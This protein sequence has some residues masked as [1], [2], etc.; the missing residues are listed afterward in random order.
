MSALKAHN[1]G[2]MVGRIILLGLA[3]ASWS[4]CDCEPKR[5]PQDTTVPDGFE[6]VMKE[7]A[8]LSIVARN[9]LIRGD[10]PVA[11]QSMRKLAFFMEHVRFPHWTVALRSSSSRHRR[12][13]T[14]KC[15]CGG[16][17]GQSK[18]CGRRC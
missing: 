16:T 2:V 18:G 1:G 10:L 4:G 7:H 12:A 13:R 17:T 15:T 5:S 6:E 8:A 14:S 9:A 3:V 11:Q